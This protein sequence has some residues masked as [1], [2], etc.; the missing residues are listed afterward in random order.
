MTIFNLSDADIRLDHIYD[1]LGLPTCNVNGNYYSTNG[2]LMLSQ[3]DF[4]IY[5]EKCLRNGNRNIVVKLPN[6][7]SIN[8]A[9][10]K[11]MH[12]AQESLGRN[13]YGVK[14]FQISSNPDQRVFQLHAM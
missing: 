14:Q 12:I 5:L 10:E 6:V 11:L 4:S 3:N 7:I 9:E 1:S 8:K 13:Q 2:M